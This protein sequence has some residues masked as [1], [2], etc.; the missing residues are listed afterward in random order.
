M[1]LIF[2]TYKI[3]LNSLEARVVRQSLF[4]IDPDIT[5][6][7]RLEPGQARSL[8]VALQDPPESGETVPERNARE[9]IFRQII[10]AL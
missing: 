7:L 10:E 6:L 5:G 3:S 2:T 9:R 1:A 8:L 4:A